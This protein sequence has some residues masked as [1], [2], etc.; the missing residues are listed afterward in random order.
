MKLSA[1]IKTFKA[2]LLAVSKLVFY[3]VFC[4]AN[5]PR[6][7]RVKAVGFRLATRLSLY[8]PR[9]FKFLSG[10]LKPGMV[11]LDVGAHLGAYTGWLA[12][13][14]KPNGSVLAFEPNPDAF[15]VLK[16]NFG[17]N[18][19]IQLYQLALGDKEDDH[20]QFEVPR[21]YG[22]LPE[23][24]LGSLKKFPKEAG[25]TVVLRTLDGL[26]LEIGRL[27]FIKVDV[28]GSELLFLAGA[29]E[30]ILRYQPLIMFEENDM[31]RQF[32]WH[33]K[34][35]HEINYR[36]YKLA[37]SGELEEYKQGR[38]EDDINY[39]LVPAGR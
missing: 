39:Y 35:A 17:D 26:K 6:Y 3:L 8:E 20:V 4:G 19:A 37:P 22:L 18:P 9:H 11:A 2:H 15:A 29:K 23:P 1:M 36:L 14:V 34:L 7:L 28:E 12:K 24:A 16:R 13:M 33:Q 30:T 10:F 25:F 38:P 32:P 27:D 5:T 21:L 31:P